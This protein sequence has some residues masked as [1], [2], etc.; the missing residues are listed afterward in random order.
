MQLPTVSV[1]LLAIYQNEKRPA[2]TLGV[3]QRLINKYPRNYLL[4]L[5][6]AATLVELKR[7]EE[8]YTTFE[9]LLKD[10]TAAAVAD[11][12]RFKYAEALADEK[13]Y[14]RAAELFLAVQQIKNAPADITTI[15]LLRAGQVYDLAGQR[16]EAVAQYKAV[17]ARP[18]IYDSREQAERGL[19]QA[20]V[21]KARDKK[22]E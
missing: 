6:T 16:N 20:Y 9:S 2:D 8:A 12:V 4:K 18:N 7:H 13:K 22:G 21:E 17:L 5:E 14:S 19:K 3:L 10:E 11:L 1:L 15:A